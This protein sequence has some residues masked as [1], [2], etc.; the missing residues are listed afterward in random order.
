MID[1]NKPLEFYNEKTGE[2]CPVERTFEEWD[3]EFVVAAELDGDMFYK[4]CYTETGEFVYPSLND[5]FT[6]VRNVIETGEQFIVYDYSDGELAGPFDTLE[7]AVEEA[8]DWIGRYR[9]SNPIVCKIV[10]EKKVGMIKV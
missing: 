9:G 1:L 6:A 7:S 5:K 4:R 3:N 10:M 2:T 8:Q